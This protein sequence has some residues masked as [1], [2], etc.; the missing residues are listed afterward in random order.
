MMTRSSYC[1]AKGEAGKKAKFCQ[2]V[3]CLASA[4]AALLTVFPL[5]VRGADPADWPMW[6]HDACRTAATPHE[7]PAALNLKWVREFPTPRPAWPSETRLHFD[8]AQEPV[9][10]GETV[11]VGLHNDKVV[12][13]DSETGK[14]KWVFFTGGPV[15]FAPV[16][17]AGR[18]F[19]ASDDGYL[20]CLDEAD[21]SLVWKFRGGPADR[22]V[23]GNERLISAWPA[24]GGP[25]LADGKVYFAAG[26][27]PFMGIFIHAIDAETGKAVW[28][29]DSSGSMKTPHAH[30][31]AT[32]IEGGPSPQGYI[33]AAGDR[34]VIP[35]GRARP[36]VLDRTN[37]RVLHYKTGFKNGSVHVSS[38]GNYYFNGAYMFDLAS[39]GVGHSLGGRRPWELLPV[40]TP[41]VAYGAAGSVF[42][43]G[44]RNV[45]IPNNWNEHTY[46]HK[47][48]KGP[49]ASVWKG[50]S[51][52]A[53]TVWLKAG[54][55]LY[56][57]IG[58]TVMAIDLPG[59]QISWK[60]DI[61][62]RVGGMIAAQ[63]RLFVS[64][65]EGRL[66]CFGTGGGPERYT[67]RESSGTSVSGK[68][69]AVLEATGV[70]AGYCLVLG[71]DD[72]KLAEGLVRGSDLHV[73]AVDADA[74]KV[75][76]L[77]RKLDAAG[78]YGTRI[79][80]HVGDPLSFP[81][82]PYLAS[83][84]VSED[85]TLKG[86][87]AEKVFPILRPYDGVACSES[88]FSASGL[89]G[90]LVKKRGDYTLL[91]RAGAPQG[92]ADWTHEGADPGNTYCSRDKLVKLPLGVLWFG[93][94]AAANI[95]HDNSVGAPRPQVADGRLI[96]E[97]PGMIHATDIYTGRLLWK[98]KLPGIRTLFAE[99]LYIPHAT[100]H[101]GGSYVSL[102]DG[103]YVRYGRK[104]LRLD[105]AT[106]RK[107]KEFSLPG[108]AAWGYIGV[109]KDLLVAG[110]SPLIFTDSED[111]KKKPWAQAFILGRHAWNGSSSEKLVVMDRTTGK[112]LW[113]REAAFGFRHHAI[114]LG[115]G[116]LFCTD[117]LPDD[118]VARLK[119]KG[120]SALGKPR[121]IAFDIRTGEELWSTS[122]DVVG[123][124][125]GYSAEH[126]IVVQAAGL[127]A[128]RKETE[129]M[130]AYRGKTGEAL[131]SRPVSGY[132]LKNF[133][134]IHRDEVI[135]D[136]GG[137]SLETGKNA[138]RM[139]QVKG[140]RVCGNPV[141]SEH[142][143]LFRKGTAATYDLE[144]KSGQ[145]SLS[146]F[147]SACTTNLIAAG[148]V[149]SAPKIF[150]PSH[151]DCN[152][153][154]RTSLALVHM[155]ELVRWNPKGAR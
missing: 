42:A 8:L 135:G 149:L 31:G 144:K 7:L 89:A 99:A 4:L 45:K 84:M 49:P 134:I 154:I 97:G 79:S 55:R 65:R 110:A 142:L 57:S 40:L 85:S 73:I 25:V 64:T 41:E 148:G 21:G 39:G 102:P 103:I 100:S 15:R 91:V 16:V 27:W 9:A 1:R 105:P 126:D 101:L 43:Y 6:R 62:S 77:R 90:A 30:G 2:S 98:T 118:M 56:A 68:A 87:A 24:R 128:G 119:P 146:G 86:D 82:P 124:W 106:G 133:G 28:T 131:W 59:G 151:C 127:A 153:P 139:K 46:E 120:G 93:G 18:L 116:K 145:H 81:F 36:A 155:P 96:V 34:L 75:D 143:L 12:A 17:A 138:W 113:S 111:A 108:D 14:E 70:K 47:Y 78:L 83:L 117:R 54:R 20:Y 19:V 140:G 109:W 74:A 92:S 95:F 10:V 76:A 61:E 13:L 88:T 147:R 123:T 37:G 112:V 58:K 125:M 80:V 150:G 67:T 137:I 44:I 132:W 130:T 11:F 51:I 35:S 72:G 115:G 38:V 129:K 53:D 63:G 122:Q 69:T 136:S 50:A 26:I 5:P 48:V 33:V 22:K 104:C 71:L 32:P 66:Y 3:W 52:D 94:P 60:A 141:G 29:N 121:L 107:V 114:A 152:F 23:I